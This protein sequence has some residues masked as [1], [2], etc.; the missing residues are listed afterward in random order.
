MEEKSKAARTNRRAGH[1]ASPICSGVDMSRPL[2]GAPAWA[3]Q[4]MAMA[5]ETTGELP[6][7]PPRC[8]ILREMIA[9]HCGE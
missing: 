5:D 9:T 2:Y 1:Q 3:Y 6:Y 8:V 4:Q 7:A